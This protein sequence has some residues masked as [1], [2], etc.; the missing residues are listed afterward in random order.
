MC[1]CAV[2]KLLT[3]YKAPEDKHWQELTNQRSSFSWQSCTEQ[4]GAISGKR[5]ARL[6]KGCATRHVTLA[7]L[8]RDKVAWQSC[9]T[10]SQV[11]RRCQFCAYC[12]R[13]KRAQIHSQIPNHRHHSTGGGGGGGGGDVLT[14][15]TTW[16]SLLTAVVVNCL[17]CN[18]LALTLMYTVNRCVQCV[19]CVNC[20]AKTSTLLYFTMN[21]WTL[22]TA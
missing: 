4:N 21:V 20:I 1:W 6:L 13:E 3:H 10:E 9:A 17:S 22:S 2:K 15:L 19:D 14:L 8:S 11:W 18:V 16:L 5:V 12:A 7:I